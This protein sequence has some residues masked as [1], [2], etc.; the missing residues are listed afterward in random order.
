MTNALRPVLSLLAALLFAEVCFAQTCSVL[1]APDP[2]ALPGGVHLDRVRRCRNKS[3]W[4]CNGV[5]TKPDYN[6][7]SGMRKEPQKKLYLSQ[8]NTP[9]K[10]KTVNLV[11]GFAGQQHAR[12]GHSSGITGQQSGYKPFS[13]KSATGWS[14]LRASSLIQDS[15]STNL[16]SRH[17]TFVGLVFDARFN[18]NFA[19]GKKTD[20]VRY[21]HNYIVSKLATPRSRVE[22]IYLAGHSRGGCLAVRLAEKLS[23]TYPT[24]RIIVHTYDPVCATPNAGGA[25][26][27]EFGVFTPQI[28]NPLNNNWKVFT[29]DFTSRLPNNK[30]MSIRSFLSGEN[31]VGRVRAFGHRGFTNTMDSLSLANGRNWYTQSFHP[32]GHNSIDSWHHGPAMNHFRQAMQMECPCGKKYVPPSPTPSPR[33]KTCA[34]RCNDKYPNCSSKVPTTEIGPCYQARYACFDKC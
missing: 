34:D 28:T 11:M 10:A 13:R 19:Q 23:Q 26:H 33:P 18:Y 9:S 2:F 4:P 30:C 3:P 8:V 7:F 25:L 17:N 22:T 32:Q 20:I 5:T 31:V 21:Y 1:S 14:T 12:K 29:T 6:Y 24:A 16:L 15:L 27:R